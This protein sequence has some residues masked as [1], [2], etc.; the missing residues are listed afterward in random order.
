MAAV[1]KTG[2]PLIANQSNKAATAKITPHP[3]HD[4]VGIGAIAR[5]RANHAI[6]LKIS[7]V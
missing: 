4:S 6:R 5:G 7:R 2:V 1:F 3:T